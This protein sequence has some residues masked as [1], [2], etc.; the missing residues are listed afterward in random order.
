MRAEAATS[1]LARLP[2]EVR[3]GGARRRRDGPTPVQ[4]LPF[5]APLMP[6]VRKSVLL[7]ATLALGLVACAGESTVSPELQSV[8]GSAS[9][10]ADKF[11]ESLSSVAWNATA[12]ELILAPGSAFVSPTGQSRALAY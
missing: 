7:R 10:G 4:P 2:P 9:I 8:R 12:R 3:Q 6:S 1:N 11:W 5:E